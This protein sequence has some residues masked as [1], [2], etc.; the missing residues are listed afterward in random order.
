VTWDL[1]PSDRFNYAKS[2]ADAA[3]SLPRRGAATIPRF[4]YVLS[5]A[6]IDPERFGETVARNRGMPVKVFT[7]LDAALS[8]L[9][10]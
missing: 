2:V 1:T 4:A 7:D 9:R 3:L 8:W 5:E 6:V 10:S